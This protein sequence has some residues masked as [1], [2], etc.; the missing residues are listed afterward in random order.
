MTQLVGVGS[1]TL[2]CG[3]L[4]DCIEVWIVV[5]V[6]IVHHSMQDNLVVICGSRSPL[7]GGD[8]G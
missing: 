8:M 6:F 5:V 7:G 1:K 3:A 4:E 2:A